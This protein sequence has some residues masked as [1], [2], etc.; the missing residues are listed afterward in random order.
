MLL[1]IAKNMFKTRVQILMHQS[2]RNEIEAIFPQFLSS[3]VKRNEAEE[4]SPVPEL[5]HVSWNN[6]LCNILLTW[7]A[8]A[9]WLVMIP[10]H[11]VKNNSYRN[12]F[13]RKT[14]TPWCGSSVM[15][16]S[17]RVVQTSTM[18]TVHA[19]SRHTPETWIWIGINS[20]WNNIGCGEA[21]KFVKCW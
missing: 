3:K 15:L 1:W 2:W 19:V 4:F 7:S 5:E 17:L 13:F 21:L 10:L 9:G 8:E 12:P 16:N 18:M 11:S 14:E 20:L 6:T